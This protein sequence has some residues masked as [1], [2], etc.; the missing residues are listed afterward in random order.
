MGS[1][2]NWQNER[3]SFSP[4]ALTSVRSHFL[5][6]ASKKRSPHRRSRM[7][8]SSM[9]N[10]TAYSREKFERQNAQP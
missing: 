3:F 5:F 6:L 8:P 10:L 9:P 7:S 2:Q 4:S 1:R